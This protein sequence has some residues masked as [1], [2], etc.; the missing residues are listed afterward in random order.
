MKMD[1]GLALGLYENIN[2]DDLSEVSVSSSEDDGSSSSSDSDEVRSGDEVMEVASTDENVTEAVSLLPSKA[3]RNAQPGGRGR[4]CRA[5]I[6]QHE[7]AARG[8]AVRSSRRQ[9]TRLAAAP[10]ATAGNATRDARV[11]GVT[12]GR[13]S[14]CKT[15]KDDD[16]HPGA[17]QQPAFWS[18]QTSRCA[19]TSRYFTNARA[20]FFQSVFWQRCV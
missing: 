2:D 6:V 13:S 10:A 18:N 20:R 5:G 19:S 15:W 17:G 7:P 14:A 1:S 11:G 9:G 16:S 3:P 8:R 4:G 12:A